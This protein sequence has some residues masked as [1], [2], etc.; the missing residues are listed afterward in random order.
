M[1]DPRPIPPLPP[2][3]AW[4]PLYGLVLAGNAASLPEDGREDRRSAAA[5][6]G[7]EAI[8]VPGVPDADSA[9][10]PCRHDDERGET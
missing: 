8:K 2:P 3:D 7:Q 6:P 10:R 9:G 1:Q 5:R 4:R